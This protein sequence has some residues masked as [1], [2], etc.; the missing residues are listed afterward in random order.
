M[1]YELSHDS[2]ARQVIEKA[3]DEMHLRR[4]LQKYIEDRHEAFLERGAQ[5]SKDDWIYISPHLQKVSLSAATERFLLEGRRA[6]I[7]RARNKRIAQVS[8][9]LFLF[10]ASLVSL[11]LWANAEKQKAETQTL[12]AE[13]ARLLAITR[14]KFEEKNYHDLLAIKDG[15][16]P[17]LYLLAVG[18]DAYKGTFSPLFGCVNDAIAIEQVFKEQKGML[19]EDVKSY[20]L[21]DSSATSANIF[22]TI[23]K[24]RADIR[25]NDFFILY[26]SGL[27]VQDTDRDSTAPYGLFMAYDPMGNPERSGIQGGAFFESLRSFESK[28]V[29][30]A[31]FSYGGNFI[32][33]LF[34]ARHSKDVSL[35]THNVFGISSCSVDQEAQE[36][37]FGGIKQGVFSYAL[38]EAID[39]MGAEKDDNGMLY[40]DELV[41]HT[42]QFVREMVDEQDVLP[43]V[44]PTFSNIPLIQFGDTFFLPENAF[45]LRGTTSEAVVKGALIKLFFE[46]ESSEESQRGH[47]F[48]LLRGSATDEQE[49]L[50]L[51]QKLGFKTLNG[52]SPA[53]REE[54]EGIN[55]WNEF[56]LRLIQDDTDSDEFI[57]LWEKVKNTSR[58]K[59]L[60]S[61][62]DLPNFSQ[63]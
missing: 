25:P 44:P 43:I 53:K 4:K 27:G 54:R 35:L 47:L 58:F 51:Y 30:I 62:Y 23:G 31:D 37:D 61:M 49:M 6:L 26:L 12:Y 24:I 42:F 21:T 18:I 38:V 29:L 41:L 2:I 5:L 40:L 32:V 16:K 52:L 8:I 39:S 9:G 19:Y 45:P 22:Q 20:L 60:I 46:I 1:R 7:R 34:E 59:R 17:D 33:P 63:N 13:Q 14:A 50:S 55:T 48:Q 10:V 15:Y 11:G 28:V 3:S 36:G 57:S 56:L